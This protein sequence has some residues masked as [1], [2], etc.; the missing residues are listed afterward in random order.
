MGWEIGDIPVN[1]KIGKYTKIDC[2]DGYTDMINV[3]NGLVGDG[4][5]FCC[6]YGVSGLR[7]L[8]DGLDTWMMV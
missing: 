3:W 8:I 1:L 7:P 2:I 5:F 6:I 4:V